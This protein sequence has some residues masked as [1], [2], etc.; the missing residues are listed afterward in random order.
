MDKVFKQQ[1]EIP[2]S[3]QNK[4]G[5]VLLFSSNEWYKELSLAEIQQVVKQNKAWYDRLAGKARSRA[6]R[7]LFG[8]APSSRVRAAGSCRT[9][10]SPNPRKPSAARC[11]W[12]WP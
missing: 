10:H 3:E 4:N 1:R 11:C 12:M 5:Y 6:V 9:A 8:K 2:M 7:P